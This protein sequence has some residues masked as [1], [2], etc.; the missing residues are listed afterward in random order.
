LGKPIW[1][2]GLVFVAAAIAALE[3]AR[4]V[5]L[6]G[7]KFH[8]AI[9]LVFTMVMLISGL[10][11][12]LGVDPGR[13]TIFLDIVAVGICPFAGWILGSSRK[14]A[15]F[16][17]SP[18]MILRIAVYLG[19]SMYYALQI[20]FMEDGRE[21]TLLLL[22]VVF[23][24]DTS[25]YFVGRAIGQIPL[26][27]SISPNKTLEGAVAGLVCAVF[28]CVLANRVLGLDAIIWEA[29]ALGLVIGVLG[30]VGDLAE[31][32]MKRK[33]GVKD[34]G[35]LIPGHGGILDR[36][37]S[38]VYVLPAAHLFILWEVQQK[39]LLS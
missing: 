3:L 9:P 13:Y 31:S 21:W 19:L 28:A 15:F 2:A 24:A 8:P 30:Q 14:M 20:R 1:F 39:G 34:S 32:R 4:L 7:D 27:P 33:A 29:A 10:S 18:V 37:D 23:A 16:D 22:L 26:A 25:A 12:G 5:N 35:W 36:L 11:R 6:W 38:I 17:S